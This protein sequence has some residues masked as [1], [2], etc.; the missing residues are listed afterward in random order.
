MPKGNTE[1]HATLETIVHVFKSSMSE[2][3]VNLQSAR[4]IDFEVMNGQLKKNNHK[5]KWQ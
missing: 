5:I 2:C 3:L 1:K 4:V